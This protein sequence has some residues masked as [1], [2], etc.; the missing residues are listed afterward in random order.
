MKITLATLL[1]ATAQQVFDQVAHHLLTQNKQSGVYTRDGLD[2]MYRGPNGLMCAAGCLIGDDEYKPS[3][4][5]KSWGAG[6]AEAGAVPSAHCNLIQDL[7]RVHDDFPPD[8]WP[9][10][11]SKVALRYGLDDAAVK[12]FEP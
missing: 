10:G 11:L 3:F 6:L 9:E 1:Q 8:A 2:C 5:F 7:Q 4:E 12:E